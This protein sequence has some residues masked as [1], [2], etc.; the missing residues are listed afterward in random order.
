MGS[1]CHLW[2]QMAPEGPEPCPGESVGRTWRSLSRQ[3]EAKAMGSV[4]ERAQDGQSNLGP[5]AAS[6]MTRVR[7]GTQCGWSQA[8]HKGSLS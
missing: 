3:H 2:E 5:G 1:L 7:D 4:W 8:N 6:G